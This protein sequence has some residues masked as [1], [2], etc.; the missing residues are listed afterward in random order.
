MSPEASTR[1][2]MPA[3]HAGMTTSGFSFSQASVSLWN[4]S[5]SS[6]GGRC[7]DHLEAFCTDCGGDRYRSYPRTGRPAAT[8]LVLFRYLCRRDCRSDVR[9]FARRCHRLDRGDFGGAV[10]RVRPVLT[11]ATREA[12]L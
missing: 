4:T 1:I 11:G 8:R 2:W 12:G 5:W 6:K 10:I 9:T 7:E 3:I